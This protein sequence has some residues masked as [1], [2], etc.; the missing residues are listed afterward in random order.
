MTQNTIDA[1]VRVFEA[2]EV[3]LAS[4]RK[5]PNTVSN[6]L[7]VPVTIGIMDDETGRL[8]IDGLVTAGVLT[9]EGEGNGA[10]LALADAPEGGKPALKL[11]G[12]TVDI[13]HPSDYRPLHER[14]GEALAKVRHELESAATEA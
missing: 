11:S 10:W 9:R 14:E 2:Q 8:A 12:E 5:A 6:I 1:I 13:D 7:G 3:L 4:V